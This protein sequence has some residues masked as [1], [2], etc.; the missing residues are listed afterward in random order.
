MIGGFVIAGYGLACAVAL[1]LSDM[2]KQP[3]PARELPAYDRHRA[4]YIATGDPAELELA[5]QH[6]HP[7]EESW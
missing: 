6:Y 5:M 3:A 4:A 1:Y 2:F 7:K